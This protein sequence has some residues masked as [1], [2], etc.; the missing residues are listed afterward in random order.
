MKPKML[1]IG[2]LLLYSS[3]VLAY[4]LWQQREVAERDGAAE[5]AGSDLGSELGETTGVRQVD[6]NP[7]FEMS[8][9]CAVCHDFSSRATAQRDQQGESVAAYDL[10]QSSM[11]AQ[12]SRDPYWRA[13]LSAEIAK[14]PS[15]KAHLEDVCTRCHT[16]MAAPFPP[17]PEGEV[18]ALLKSDSHQAKLAMDGVSCTVCHQI[19]DTNLGKP[20][21]FTGNFEI[22]TESLIY[23]PHANPVTMPMRNNVGFTPTH[24]PHIM[25][26][27]LCATCHTVI[28]EA[29]TGDGDPTGHHFHEQTPYLEWRNSVFNDELEQPDPAAE[30]CQSCHMP[31]TGN[32]GNPIKTRLAHNPGGRDFPFLNPREPFGR[33]TLVGGNALMTRI[34]RDNASELGV[35]V[36]AAAFDASLAEIE[37]MLR[38]RT[39]RLTFGEILLDE[40]QL[41]IPLTVTNLAGHKFPTA[42][43]SR[44]AWIELKVFDAEDQ[45]IFVSGAY[46][47][48]G[49]LVDPNHQVLP[50][51]LAGGETLPHY[52]V[53]EQPRQ[54]QVY[55][56]LMGDIEGQPTFY[57]LQG[58]GFLK[59]NRL[60][61]RGWDP[62]HADAS[63][64][65]PTGIGN[66]PDFIGGS[67]QLTYRIAR[68]G[69]TPYRIEASLLFQTISPRHAAELFSND[70]PEV[71]RFRIFFEGADT[72]P[73]WIDQQTIMLDD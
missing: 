18:L 42:Y 63:A 62:D 5:A 71:N 2:V 36:P 15:Q 51:E 13:V 59:D 39:A 27:A 38:Q 32:D 19:S 29:V 57:L 61:P 10:W 41:L 64:T 53:I 16:P 34:L 3:G 45:L 54:V 4:L 56:S 44:R 60:L 25:K 40:Q 35:T 37:K 72:R 65:F 46:N 73:E 8:Q 67:D 21:S 49:E 24:S 30:S 1:V 31:T 58:A 6:L 50:S 11:M 70:T 22:N 17:S 68:S 14:T 52:Q 43:P 7:H 47:E 26:S 55:E 20:E 23:G 66:D 9:R 69:R 48:R 33:H 28:T 12:S